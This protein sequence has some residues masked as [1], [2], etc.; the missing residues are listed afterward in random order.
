MDTPTPTSSK[1]LC[2]TRRITILE[3]YEVEAVFELQALRR[4]RRLLAAGEIKPV[5]NEILTK[6]HLHLTDV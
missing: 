5:R 6:G 3:T 2:I 1:K 4:L